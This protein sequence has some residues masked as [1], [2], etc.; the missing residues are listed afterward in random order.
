VFAI[1]LS[2]S[3]TGCAATLA[4]IR[5][6]ITDFNA[7]LAQGCPK[8]NLTPGCEAARDGSVGANSLFQATT[9]AAQTGKDITELLVQ[10]KDALESA[11]AALKKAVL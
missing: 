3:L 10:A 8:E 2:L 1:L 6:G 5:T 7:A 4:D 11:W 9:L